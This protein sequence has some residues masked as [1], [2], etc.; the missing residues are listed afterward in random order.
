IAVTLD[1]T[2][3]LKP[4][5]GAAAAPPRP[6]REATAGAGPVPPALPAPPRPPATEG[7]TAPTPDVPPARTNRQFGVVVAGQTIF[8]PAP[9]VIPRFALYAMAALEHA[10]PWAPALFI[11]AVHAWRGDLPEPGGTASFSLDA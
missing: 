9:A 8:G 11:G 7:S 1:P 2:Q 10:G 6:A 5:P 3:T 4:A